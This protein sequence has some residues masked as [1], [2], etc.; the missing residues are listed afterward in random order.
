MM[1]N[2]H[3]VIWRFPKM[4]ST[5]NHPSHDHDVVLKPM[6]T[7]G[8]HHSR[9]PQ[10]VPQKKKAPAVSETQNDCASSKTWASGRRFSRERR[11][12]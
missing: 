12:L 3:M 1:F 2:F 11:G 4:G 10:N 6:V 9:K 8:Y 7:W 5:P